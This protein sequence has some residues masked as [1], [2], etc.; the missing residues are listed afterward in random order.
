[1]DEKR[2]S[3][4]GQTWKINTESKIKC[5]GDKNNQKAVAIQLDVIQEIMA[6]Q[7]QFKY[8]F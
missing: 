8:D 5:H 3:E 6:L 1:M 2:V 4:K 7:N